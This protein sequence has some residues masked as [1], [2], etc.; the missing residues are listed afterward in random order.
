LPSE[1]NH[2]ANIWGMKS[3]GVQWIVS[4]SAVGSLQAKY[5]P[6][7]IVIPDQFFDR[8]KQSAAHTFFGNGIVAH[9]A[10]AHP[11]CETL[12]KIAFGATKEVLAAT[13][14]A[15]KPAKTKGKKVPPPRAHL[16]GTYVNMEG[17]A[18][19]TL[20]ESN[21]HRRLGFD[22]VGMTN[23]GEAKCARE[24][25]IHY[26]TLALVT[27]YDCWHPRHDSVTVEMIIGYLTQNAAN[28]K[29]IIKTIIGQIPSDAA[30]VPCKCAHA[31]KHAI[32]TDKKVWPE[33]TRKN[34]ELLLRKYF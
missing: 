10:F 31:L 26:A 18:F 15:K 22:L 20:A 24:A 30:Q 27:D 6:L 23:L 4:A 1:L 3:L 21:A 11:F 8:T 29:Q 13:A 28:A 32:M 25:E 33:P 2:R 17:P 16:G 34:L 14:K 9:I 19:S 7:D 5:R 12:R